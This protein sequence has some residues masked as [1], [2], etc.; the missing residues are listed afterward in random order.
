MPR[1]L[2][3]ILGCH[4]HATADELCAAWQRLSVPLEREAATSGTSA[5]RLAEINAA[6]GVL[7][8]PEARAAY[9]ATLPPEA[10]D[11]LP[12]PEMLP[13]P[14]GR[15]LFDWRA[16]RLI[17]TIA[18]LTLIAFGWSS[19]RAW[20]W[21]RNEAASAEAWQAE[22]RAR[23]AAARTEGQTQGGDGAPGESWEARAQRDAD[24][25]AFEEARR[26]S[27]EN[28]ADRER[29]RENEAA[30]AQAARERAEAE[31]EQAREDAAEEAQRQRE[32]T[33]RERA[34]V[35]RLQEE[36]NRVMRLR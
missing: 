29:N 8:N 15:P 13:E 4:P 31:R 7:G 9:D 5:S 27:D 3:Q 26:R 1:T 2:Y 12:E 33:E 25:R 21:N 14:A 10:F 23:E 22:L 17:I 35:E 32:R 20:M 36:N 6:W 11:V 30:E 16:G 28:M 34:E 24:Q 19:C 18:A